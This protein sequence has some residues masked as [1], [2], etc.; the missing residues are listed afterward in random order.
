M[1]LPGR[2]YQT[3][4]SAAGAFKKN[5]ILGIEVIDLQD[6]VIDILGADFGMDQVEFHRLERKH[7]QRAGRILG[8]SLID[9]D[10]Y[11]R[12]G[13]HRSIDQVRRNQLLRD[14]SIHDRLCPSRL[15]SGSARSCAILVVRHTV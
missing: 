11:W 10:R 12:A 1:P 4:K 8:Q 6:V 7:D 15:K 14:V 9:P 3:P 5:V 13:L 2:E